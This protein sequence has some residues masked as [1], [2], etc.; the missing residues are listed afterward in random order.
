MSPPTKLLVCWLA[1]LS[2][3]CRSNAPFEDLDAH[4]VGAGRTVVWITS[5]HDCFGC[6]T[7]LALLRQASHDLPQLRILIL[8][9]DGD[10][11]MF[12]EMVTRERIRARVGRVDLSSSFSKLRAQAPLLLVLDG[13]E[14]LAMARTDVPL[15]PNLTSAMMAL[16]SQNL[17]SASSGTP[18]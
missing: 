17:D 14:L 12:R 11:S 16:A 6:S 9:V 8:A 1:V 13:R 3:A 5:E 10:T 18:H 2:M 7:P 15:S 4:L